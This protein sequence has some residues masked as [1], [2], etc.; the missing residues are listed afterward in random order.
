MWLQEQFAK[1][2]VTCGECGKLLDGASKDI[3]VD[4]IVDH[5]GDC[6]L[7]WD[8]S[9]LQALHQRCHSVKTARENGFRK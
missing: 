2:N 6:E 9:N 3:H 8:E 1:G 5:K 7:M 4:H